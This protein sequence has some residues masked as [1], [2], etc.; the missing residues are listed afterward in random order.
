MLTKTAEC[1]VIAWVARD[2]LGGLRGYA[3]NW[4]DDPKEIEAAHDY[5]QKQ[6]HW[7]YHEISVSTR[8]LVWHRE[9]VLEAYKK[10]L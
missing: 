9:Q 7:F 3:V 10:G 4:S 2:E 6:A 1:V 8:A 5:A